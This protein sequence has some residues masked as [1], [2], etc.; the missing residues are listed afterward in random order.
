MVH[1]VN[2]K[3]LKATYLL[4]VSTSTTNQLTGYCDHTWIE[5]S[6]VT[7]R[8]YT[9][10]GIAARR[11]PPSA[12]GWNLGGS[13]HPLASTHPPSPDTVPIR[14]FRSNC[15]NFCASLASLRNNRIVD[16]K[17]LV[18]YQININLLQEIYSVSQKK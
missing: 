10:I 7:G 1:C 5:G 2:N 13:D 15:R 6:S 9:G 12:A 17:D 16:I 4:T 18:V 3:W 14:L 8:Q 11:A